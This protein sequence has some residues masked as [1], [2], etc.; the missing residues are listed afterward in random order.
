MLAGCVNNPLP[1]VSQRTNDDAT[2]AL[3]CDELTTRNNNITARVK[4]LEA[5]QKRT[6]R[7]NALT[8][9]VVNVGLGTVMGAGMRGGLDGMRAASATVQGVN[10]VRSAEQSHASMA[11]VTDSLAL[12]QRSAELQ[13]AYVEKGC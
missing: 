6:A 10:A 12:M 2:L 5:E 3:S 8:N 1:T 13:R 9:T 11:N 7:T 4:E